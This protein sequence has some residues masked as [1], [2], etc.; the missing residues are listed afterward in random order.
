MSKVISVAN[1]K[2][3]VG[4]TTTTV[5]LAAA[6][7][8]KGKT[9]L[10]VDA[11]PQANSSSGV[12]IFQ[13]DVKVSIYDCMVNVV[14]PNTAI[15]KTDKN[16]CLGVTD[17][18]TEVMALFWGQMLNLVLSQLLLLLIWEVHCC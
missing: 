10:L 15:L 3:G 16:V 8:A 17:E 14:D 7:G 18:R 1:Q 2:G 4:K 5:N 9:V 13:G 11:D 6:L 12:G